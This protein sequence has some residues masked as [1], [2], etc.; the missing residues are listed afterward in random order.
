MAVDRFAVFPDWPSG[1]ATITSPF[2]GLAS[3][4]P[5]AWQTY[6][7]DLTAAEHDGGKKGKSRGAAPSVKPQHGKVTGP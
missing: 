5:L 3:F 1:G 2:F 6:D 4:P 7:V